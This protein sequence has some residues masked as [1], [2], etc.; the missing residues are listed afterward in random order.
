MCSQAASNSACCGCVGALH[1]TL[2]AGAHTPVG[3]VQCIEDVWCCRRQQVLDVLLQGVDVLQEKAVHKDD[4]A[5]EGVVSDSTQPTSLHQGLC[6][7][8]ASTVSATA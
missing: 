7:C 4:I 1:L 6:N 2:H 8:T 5:R 3:V